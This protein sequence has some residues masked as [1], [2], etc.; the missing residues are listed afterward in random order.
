MNI[1]SKACD[2]SLKT[3]QKVWQRDNECCIYCGNHQ[4]MPSCHYIGRS[5][6]G[7]G[8]EQNI[9]T[10]C[11][12]CHRRY[13]Q[14]SERQKYREFIKNYLKEQYVNWDEDMLIYKKGG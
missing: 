5:Q 14:T 1:R 8:I 6:G 2:I 3:K 4:A 9:V 10:L 11:L 7:L 12:E 13:D